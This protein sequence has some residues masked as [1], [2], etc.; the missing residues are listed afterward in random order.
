MTAKLC[1]ASKVVLLVLLVLSASGCPKEPYRAALSGSDSVAASVHAAIDITSQYYSSNLVNDQEKKVVGEALQVVTES[2][3]T[4]RSCATA[5]HNSGALG[6]SPYLACA[7][8]FVLKTASFD[9]TTFGFKN[10]KAQA[11]LS[12]YLKAVKTAIDGVSLAVQS[13]KGA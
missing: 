8:S 11:D 7:S 3:M 13:A 2:N 9:P 1:R 12:N 5:Y 6:K 10:A 4:F